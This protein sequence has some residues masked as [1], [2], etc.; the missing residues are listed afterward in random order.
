MKSMHLIY[1][2]AAECRWMLERITL[3][4]SDTHKFDKKKYNRT[5]QAI[6]E[7]SVLWSGLTSGIERFIAEIKYSIACISDSYDQGCHI[8]ECVTS[9]NVLVGA[10]RQHAK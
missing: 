3:K 5:L 2:T 4:R 10:V 8:E 9:F 7:L 1:R 6:P